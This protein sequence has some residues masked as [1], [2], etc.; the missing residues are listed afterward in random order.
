MERATIDGIE[1]E[2]ELSGAGDPVVCIHGAF[3]ADAFRPLLHEPG[4]SGRYQIIAYHRRDYAGSSRCAGCV[5]VAG[6]AADC[7]GLLRHL[8]IERAHVVGHSYG[9]AVALQLALDSPNMVHS[10][11]LLE[12]ALMVGDSAQGYRESLA[13]SIERFRDAGAPGVV[14]EFLQARW[15]GYRGDLDRIL[16]GAFAQAVNDAETTFECELPGLLDWSFGQAEARRIR[17]PVLSMLGGA[18]DALWPRFG[19]THRLL[20]AWL[21]NA[22]GFVLPGAAHMMQI[23]DPRGV[24]EALV[25]FWSRHPIPAGDA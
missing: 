15:P 25:A 21:P 1:L 6:Q 23:E 9:G 5:G 4:R 8:G 17:R 7:R 11:A 3:I 2:Y 13:R 12:P 24:A 19:E 20:L 14:D 10:L 18:S 22:E 16:P